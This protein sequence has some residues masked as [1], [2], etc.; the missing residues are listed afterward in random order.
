MSSTSLARS[1]IPLQRSLFVAW[2]YTLPK[3]A[4]HSSQE[5]FKRCRTKSLIHE[6]ASCLLKG[7]RG[8]LPFNDSLQVVK[9]LF[10][11]F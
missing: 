5:T 7:T 9:L 1:A 8:L 6:Y 3:L 11:H 2:S 4:A 10:N